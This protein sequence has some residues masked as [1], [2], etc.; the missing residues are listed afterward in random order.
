MPPFSGLVHSCLVLTVSHTAVHTWPEHRLPWLPSQVHPRVKLSRAIRSVVG[1][2]KIILA[3]FADVYVSENPGR[4]W[5]ARQI[6][7]RIWRWT[8]LN[9]AAQ[10]GRSKCDCRR[11]E[12]LTFLRRRSMGNLN[13]CCYLRFHFCFRAKQQFNAR[14]GVGRIFSRGRGT[15]GFFQ[16]GSKKWWDL[17][18]PTRN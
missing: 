2:L 13:S 14:M 15:R 7:R 5:L 8:F 10:G 12:V 6:H 16:G 3:L 11:S 4:T 1:A 17:F 9:P 18:F